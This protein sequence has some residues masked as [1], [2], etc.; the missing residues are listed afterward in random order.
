MRATGASFSAGVATRG[1]SSWWRTADGGASWT[2][3]GDATNLAARLMAA[4]GDTR[5]STARRQSEALAESVHLRGGRQI[6]V[7][8][9]A[10]LHRRAEVLGLTSARALRRGRRHRGRGSSRGA[11]RSR[12]AGRLWARGGSIWLAGAAGSGESSARSSAGRACAASRRS[13]APSSRSAWAAA[14]PCSPGCLAALGGSSADELADR[15]LRS[16]R[17]ACPLAA[18]RAVLGRLRVG[19]RPCASRDGRRT[20]RARPAAW[21][22]TCSARIRRRRLRAR[23][24]PLGPMRPGSCS[25]T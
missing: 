24:R 9:K 15:S 11:R 1:W 21:L 6:A 12:R 23:G 3:L 5:S 14:R 17:Q 22:S 4:G 18:A 25:W 7:K 20:G 16:D 2:G 19:R 10:G 13:T 8:G